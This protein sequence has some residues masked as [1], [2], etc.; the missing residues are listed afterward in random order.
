MA[1]YRANNESRNA[2]NTKPPLDSDGEQ[3]GHC[4]RECMTVSSIP[5]TSQAGRF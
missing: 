1:D 5:M 2:V 3:G 4:Q